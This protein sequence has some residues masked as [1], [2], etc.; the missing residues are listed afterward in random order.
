[1]SG[2][3]ANGGIGGVSLQNLQSMD[4]ETALMAVQQERT[5]LLDTQLQSQIQEVQNRN[6][7]IAKLNTVLSAL[8]SA[9]AQFK[10]GASA[11]D[12]IPD[13]NNDKVKAIEIPLNDAIKAAG[14]GDLGFTARQG[15]I[16]NPSD[17]M[18]T[19]LPAAT[20]IMQGGT[21][22]GEIDGAI[23]KVKGMIDSAG[24]SQ[25][26]DML[27]LQSMTNKRNEAFDVMT[28]FVKKMQESRSSIIGNMR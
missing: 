1:M 12:T 26:M 24:N 3:N 7:M 22:K 20:N 14:L 8:N 23:N 21:T 16:S 25:Q 19:V 11:T 4:L 5:R 15:R 27:R 6:D 13:W 28:N 17:S 18:G 2:I 9:A 10:S